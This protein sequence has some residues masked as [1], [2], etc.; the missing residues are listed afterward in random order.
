[1]KNSSTC[2][3]SLLCNMTSVESEINCSSINEL[4]IFKWSSLFSMTSNLWLSWCQLTA[5]NFEREA[6]K[7]HLTFFLF[8]Q[9][10]N[11][12]Y[13]VSDETLSNWFFTYLMISMLMT[14]LKLKF[15]WLQL[16][17]LSW[18]ENVKSSSLKK[19][20]EDV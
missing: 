12:F 20:D 19:S 16:C 13:L 5:F 7:L 17:L 9:L 10:Q 15:F 18:T 3:C 4:S 11:L 8:L 1:M 2:W 14:L 6:V